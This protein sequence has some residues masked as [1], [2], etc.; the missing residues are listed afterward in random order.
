MKKERLLSSPEPPFVWIT[1]DILK[2]SSTEDEP[3]RCAFIKLQ[4][5]FLYVS[6]VQYVEGRRTVMMLSV[7]GEINT[8]RKKETLKLAFYVQ[9]FL[10][11]SQLSSTSIGLTSESTVDLNSLSRLKWVLG[12]AHAKFDVS[13]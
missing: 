6:N 7:L 13:A 5:H 11:N 8:K 10:L 3:I 2:T 1:D 12:S 9:G 4:K